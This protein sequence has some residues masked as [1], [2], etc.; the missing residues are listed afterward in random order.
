[1][2]ERIPESHRV[3]ERFDADAHLVAVLNPVVH[4][5]AVHRRPNKAPEYC[6]ALSCFAIHSHVSA[7]LGREVRPESWEA[8]TEGQALRGVERAHVA[9]ELASARCLAAVNDLRRPRAALGFRGIGSCAQA[10]TTLIRPAFRERGFRRMTISTSW[11]SAVNRFIS[12]ST[13]KPTS[14]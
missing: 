11:S 14:L 5:E 3:F 6:G 7:T 8:S 12:R 4:I 1:M 10:A 13:E 9:H 2:L